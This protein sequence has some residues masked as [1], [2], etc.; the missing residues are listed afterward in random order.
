M[1]GL[2]GCILKWELNGDCSQL[3]VEMQVIEYIL[4]H[5]QLCK[6]KTKAFGAGL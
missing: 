4:L 3:L 5:G 1:F 6:E 2:D